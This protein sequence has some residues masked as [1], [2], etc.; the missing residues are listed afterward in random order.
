MSGEKDINDSR[1]KALKLM[2]GTGTA[3]L[4]P[5]G[6]AA[7]DRRRRRHGESDDGRTV[8]DNS[9]ELVVS[10]ENT[11][12]ELE[13]TGS[14]KIV[15]ED[16]GKTYEI[17]VGNDD[18]IS[19]Q[20]DVVRSG[21]VATSLFGEGNYPVDICGEFY[22]CGGAFDIDLA[23][24]SESLDFACN[25]HLCEGAGFDVG[26]AYGDYDVC[27]YGDYAEIEYHVWVWHGN[28]TKEAKDTIVIE[29]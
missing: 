16:D 29:K 18:N 5:T 12:E 11:R 20:A 4:F 26:A 24:W 25:E 22:D 7:A 17:Y 10:L 13:K 2:A 6:A 28:G 9:D 27:F 1:R 23:V 8:S 3:A 14:N 21:C 19:A 15:K